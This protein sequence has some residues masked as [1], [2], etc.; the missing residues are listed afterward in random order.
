MQYECGYGVRVQL[1]C[2]A[3]TT[4]VSHPYQSVLRVVSRLVAAHVLVLVA[5]EIVKQRTLSKPR[6]NSECTQFTGY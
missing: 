5:T 2:S 3:S 1:M 4:L 6:R